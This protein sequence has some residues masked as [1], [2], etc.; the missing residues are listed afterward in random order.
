MKNLAPLQRV[1]PVAK[2]QPIVKFN[3]LAKVDAKV[4]AAGD[5]AARAAED[6]QCLFLPI[7]NMS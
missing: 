2:V 7:E 3:P 1:R 4:D 6:L 5:D